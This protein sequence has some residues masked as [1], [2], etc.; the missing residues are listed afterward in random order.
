VRGVPH[1]AQEVLLPGRG[2]APLGAGAELP[3]RVR[4][5]RARG[6]VHARRPQPRFRQ[7]EPT[8]RILRQPHPL[9]P[10]RQTAVAVMSRRGPRLG[11]YSGPRKVEMKSLAEAEGRREVLDRM[12]RLAP[13]SRPRWG[14]MSVGQMICHLT[15]NLRMALG[16]IETRSKNKKLYQSF[17]VKQLV[18]YW[19]P[20][21]KG[22]PT[23]PELLVTAPATFQ[24]DADRLR[25]LVERFGAESAAAEGRN[26]PLFGPL[27]ATAWGVLQY[28]HCDH[29]LGQFGV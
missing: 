28:R 11:L 6:P 5:P 12:S 10:P 20:W 18:I 21:P 22:V 8:G 7:G 15:D 2:R 13:D 9:P 26:H 3:P 24:A 25:G 29:H 27:S 14:G 23:A 1:A 19:L 17:P 4:V 16:D